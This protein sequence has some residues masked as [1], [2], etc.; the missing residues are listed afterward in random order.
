MVV[1]LPCGSVFKKEEPSSCE[2]PSAV[3]RGSGNCSSSLGIDTALAMS[4]GKLYRLQGLGLSLGW[5]WS[6]RKKRGERNDGVD[7]YGEPWT[8][9]RHSNDPMPAAGRAARGRRAMD[10]LRVKEHCLTTNAKNVQQLAVGY[11]AASV[12]C[13]SVSLSHIL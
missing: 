10:D 1:R 11:L 4:G 6:R 13:W 12:G 2:A 3:D 8:I 9:Q 5:K 7:M